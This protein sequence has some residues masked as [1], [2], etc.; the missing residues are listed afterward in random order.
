MKRFIT[1]FTILTLITVLA[2][3]LGV[4]RDNNL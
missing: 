4:A 2:R 3:A 1:T